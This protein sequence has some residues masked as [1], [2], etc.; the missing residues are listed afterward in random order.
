MEESI[1]SDTVT[2][3][4]KCCIEEARILHETKDRNFG[5]ERRRVPE[6]EMNRK[7]KRFSDLETFI[8]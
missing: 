7:E 8:V 4:A 3:M 6:S 1:S 5:L 2:Q